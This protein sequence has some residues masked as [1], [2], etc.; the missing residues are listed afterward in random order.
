MVVAPDTNLE[1][2][3][4]LGER[5]RQTVEESFTMFKGERV[6]IT[7]SVGMAVAEPE[8]VVGYDMMRHAAAAALSEAK[9]SGRNRAI[10]RQ[11]SALAG[12]TVG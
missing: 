1:G 5:I 2:A 10:I 7:V 8:V 4:T 9:Q 12:P 3:A 6:Q 11:L